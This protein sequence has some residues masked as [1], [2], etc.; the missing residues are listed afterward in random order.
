MKR[1]IIFIISIISLFLFNTPVFAAKIINSVQMNI[2]IDTEGVAT[3]NEIWQIN[4]QSNVTYYEK[5]FRE[6][7]NASID[8]IMV[9]SSKS[10]VYTSVDKFDNQDNTY[11]YNV[12]NKKSVLTFKV[13]NLED[14]Y[15]IQYQIKGMINSYKDIQG[16]DWYLISR[17]N[18]QDISTI[19]IYISGP[20]EFNET[21][22]ALYVVS[23]KDVS[24]QFDNG[25]ISLF[26]SNLSAKSQIRF[27]TTFT[28]L[29]FS[30]TKKNKLT[31]NEAYEDSKNKNELLDELMDY[32][33]K[34]VIEVALI[35]IGLIIIFVI[36]NK[37]FNRVKKYNEFS[38][39]ISEVKPKNL[40]MENVNY[41]EN[42]P[43]NGDIYKLAFISGYYK[44]SKNR[45]DII[46]AILL[47][48]LY[49]G[50]VYIG[51]DHD[52]PYIKLVDNQ[53]FDRQ[54]DY[55][56][57]Q[58]LQA[59]SNYNQIDNTRFI[60]Y[61]SQHYLRIITWFNMGFNESI[62]DEF[63]R[64]N[65]KRIKKVKKTEIVLTKTIY[66]YAVQIMGVKK[67]LL[68]FNQVPRQTELTQ[69]GYKYLLIMA[70]LLGIGTQVAKEI[71]RKNPDNYM[72]KSLLDMEDAKF[73]FRGAYQAALTPYKEV[74]KHNKIKSSYDAELDDLLKQ[75]EE[76]T[77]RKS[78]L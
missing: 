58:M 49:E 25:K 44:I 47:K 15:T 19:N 34:E 38:G 56:L 22:T 39:I 11:N 13:N 14:T 9:S 29:E 27:M 40:K 52:R 24:C 10:G 54:L 75:K 7:D 3:V 74:M 5:N 41:C 77:E 45:S 50:K 73:L 65:I 16:I 64:G 46:G 59:S 62:N 8:N 26:A 69:E 60:R 31:F 1:K 76:V 28:N 42:V 61:A 4:N 67:Y 17:N 23:N 32:L 20:V 71:L 18:Y 2:N 55:D 37:V 70:E 72:A 78:V 48:W 43:C 12:N 51:R 33:S 6:I 66:D 35:V 21:N 68:N 63:S 30:N 57:Y 53:Y 36:V